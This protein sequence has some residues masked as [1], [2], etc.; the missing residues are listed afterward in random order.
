VF[1]VNPDD[2]TLS[3]VGHQAAGIKT[4]RNFGI[5]STGKFML[6]ANQGSNSVIVFTI[7]ADTGKLK[8]TGEK[9]E[10]GTPV[11]VKFVTKAK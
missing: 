3:L 5:D 10:V 11:C 8:P 7:D 2:G 9:I 6:V 4:P 1:K